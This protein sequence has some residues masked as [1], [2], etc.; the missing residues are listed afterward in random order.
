MVQSAGMTANCTEASISLATTDLDSA[1]ESLQAGDTEVVQ[2]PTGQPYVIRD[3][4]FRDRAGN[5]I[6][7]LEL[8]PAGQ[9]Q[10]D[11][12]SRSVGH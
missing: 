2:E 4:A 8:R 1:F 3:C 9:L 10:I 12:E 6:G 5:L 7:I 11:Q